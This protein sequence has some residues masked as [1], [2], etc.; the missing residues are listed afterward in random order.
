M[1]T[2]FAYN[3][4][5]P[6]AAISAEISVLQSRT[7]SFSQQ[8]LNRRQQDLVLG[9]L[10]QCNLV[11]DTILSN[12]S[13]PQS[14]PLIAAITAMKATRDSYVVGPV[15]DAANETVAQMQLQLLTEL[16]SSGQLPAAT[17]LS[18]FSASGPY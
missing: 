11:A 4:T 2:V 9:F 14:N 10:A 16:M 18:Q 5:S 15:F 7:D 3:D 8:L 6:L 13:Y 17:I 12:A 1:T